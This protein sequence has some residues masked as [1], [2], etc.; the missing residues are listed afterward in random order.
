[1]DSTTVPDA[2]YNI[3]C[4]GSSTLS[5]V[6]LFIY[7]PTHS[8]YLQVLLQTLLTAAWL[9]CRYFLIGLLQPLGESA[10]CRSELSQL[11]LTGW[12]LLL[13][14]ADKN[15]SYH[16][17]ICTLSTKMEIQKHSFPLLCPILLF[18][19]SVFEGA[20]NIWEIVHLALDLGLV[21]IRAYFRQLL[22]QSLKRLQITGMF[23]QL[24]FSILQCN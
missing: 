10:G 14:A 22:G 2:K 23:S 6:R 5:A 1:M 19:D 7:A 11:V 8:D 20:E 4:C 18:F 9:N 13:P 24:S 12:H 21:S 16:A 17:S 15:Q 3:N